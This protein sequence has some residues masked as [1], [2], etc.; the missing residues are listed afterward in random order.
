MPL[1][2]FVLMIVLALLG[3]G[4]TVFVAAWA[5]AAWQ[6]PAL[7]LAVAVPLVM[8]AYVVWRV[9]A[10]RMAEGGKYDGR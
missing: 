4:V 6:L 3:A 5:V 8:A 1:D 10:D 7:G 2:K 9:V